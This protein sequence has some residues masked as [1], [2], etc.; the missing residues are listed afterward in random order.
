MDKISKSAGQDNK[1]ELKGFSNGVKELVDK[2]PTLSRK[3][4][5]LEDDGWDIKYGEL[6]QGSYVDRKDKLMV[7]DSVQKATNAGV[8]QSLAHESGHATFKLEAIIP[9]EG[10]PK[11]SMYMEIPTGI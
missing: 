10:K 9:A 1:P 7:I 4:K 5:S 3:L 8:V 6:K 2:S 11:V